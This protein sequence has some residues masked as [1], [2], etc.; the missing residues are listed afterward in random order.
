MLER[1]TDQVFVAV[2]GGA[3]EVTIAEGGGDA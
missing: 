3:V 2:D 1:F